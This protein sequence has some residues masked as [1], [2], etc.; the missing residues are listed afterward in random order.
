MDIDRFLAT[1]RPA[2]DRLTEL[3]RRSSGG[4]SRLSAA[5]IDELVSLYQ[6][7]SAHLSYA[8]TYYRDPAL[9]AQLTGLVAR[10]GAVV[11]GT[12][13]RTLRALGRFVSVTFPG[14]LWHIRRFVL[15]STAL[16]LAVAFAVALWIS[17]S[18]AALDASAPAAVREAYV[19]QRFEDYYSA[20]PSAQFASKVFTN[21]VRVGF[22]AFA[23]GVLL[24][25][26]TVFI[27]AQNAANLGFAAGLFAVAGQQLKF[28][29]LILPHG[30]LELTAVFVAG[31]A[32]LR[33][34]WTVIDPGDR[35]R[36]AAL[37]Q[38]GR[39]AFTVV[40]GLVA[41]FA[42]GILIS[43]SLFGVALA[44]LMSTRAL[45]RT[46]SIAAGAMAV[47]SIALGVF[48]MTTA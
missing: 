10:A 36:S 47:A 19:N 1:N 24:C 46:S 40:L 6:R 31:G 27:L 45:Q 30:L 37:A 3:T 35:R 39:I 26:L 48:W 16:S 12:R 17:R 13:P 28:W 15:V 4:L 2:W 33:L 9:V 5:E 14:A 21:N 25:G 8:R 11:Y 32:G 22:L 18:P 20:E 42:V 29:G 7:V 44:R 41:V 23:G 43:M 34:G 38:E